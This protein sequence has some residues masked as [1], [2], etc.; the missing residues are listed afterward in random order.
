MTTPTET[1]ADW[2]TIDEAAEIVGRKPRQ[3]YRWLNDLEQSVTKIRRRTV[4][5]KTYVHLPS[6]T[7]YEAT[8]RPGRPRKNT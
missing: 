7:D 1:S 2:K 4:G 8:V 5:R 6:L 3:V